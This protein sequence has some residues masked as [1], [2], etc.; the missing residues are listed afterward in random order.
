MLCHHSQNGNMIVHSVMAYY[1][2][3]MRQNMVQ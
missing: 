2:H 1:T 3:K